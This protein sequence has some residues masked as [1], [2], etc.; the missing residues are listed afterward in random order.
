MKQQIILEK[1]TCDTYRSEPLPSCP[2]LLQ[3]VGTG[4]L[5]V[6]VSVDGQRFS[7]LRAQ[8]VEGS[9]LRTINLPVGGHFAVEVK[10]AKE[11][12]RV[13]MLDTNP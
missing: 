3:M 5:V 13:F 4:T 2:L 12:P 7:A 1:L 6:H 10:D 8:S 9:A 11:E